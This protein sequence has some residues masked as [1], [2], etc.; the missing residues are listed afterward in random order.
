MQVEDVL[1]PSTCVCRTEEG[2]L[3]DGELLVRSRARSVLFFSVCGVRVFF[4]LIG[5]CQ[6]MCKMCAVTVSVEFIIHLAS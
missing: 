3:L 6:E 1:T 5:A 4:C 2:R